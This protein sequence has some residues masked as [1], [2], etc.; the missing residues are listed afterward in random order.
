MTAM[1]C[2][3]TLRDEAPEGETE[4]RR[5]GQAECIAHPHD[6]VG[7]GIEVPL[8]GLI[9]AIA[10]AIAAKVQVDHP[11]GVSGARLILTCLK[12]MKRRLLSRGLVSLCIGGGQ[13]GAV[14]LER[15]S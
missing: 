14:L 4:H 7:P 15:K 1:A 2:G 10:S 12:E 3:V 6:I 8:L 13:G 9:P 11:V 5:V